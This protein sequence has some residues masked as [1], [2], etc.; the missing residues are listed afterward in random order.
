MRRSFPKRGHV[1]FVAHLYNVA[2]LAVV[3]LRTMRVEHGQQATMPNG[4]GNVG[5]SNPVLVV[6][7]AFCGV[8]PYNLFHTISV[9]N[10]EPIAH[11]KYRQCPSFCA[12]AA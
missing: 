2:A 10:T 1:D 7:V 4:V 8:T 11:T 3:D 12:S 9:A 5:E 6:Y